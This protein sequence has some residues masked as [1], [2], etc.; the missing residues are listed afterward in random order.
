MCKRHAI[1][2]G[3]IDCIYL[4]DGVDCSAEGIAKAYSEHF[5][6]V[7]FM[8]SNL[9]EMALA[10]NEAVPGIAM[11]DACKIAAHLDSVGYCRQPF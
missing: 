4:V 10:V 8:V 9:G 5:E 2:E 7:P 1:C 6:P 11:I 3:Q